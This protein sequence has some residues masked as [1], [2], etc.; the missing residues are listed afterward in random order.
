MVV[1]FKADVPPSSEGS[2]E[3]HSPI[4]CLLSAFY[5]T[6]FFLLHFNQDVFTWCSL[7]AK[8]QYLLRMSLSNPSWSFLTNQVFFIFLMK[9][10]ETFV[11]TPVAFIGFQGPFLGYR[12]EFTFEME[13]TKVVQ[14][15]NFILLLSV[16]GDGS[17][18]NAK[19]HDVSHQVPLY[20]C[21]RDATATCHKT[22]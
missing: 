14:R 20:H 18:I 12:P 10:K 2:R 7:L 4:V 11:T 22:W 5:H 19:L 13:Q 17:S 3:T 8:P 21:H 9:Y 15:R 6:F 16:R 1:L